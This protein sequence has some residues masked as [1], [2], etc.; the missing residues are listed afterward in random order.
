VSS[1]AKLFSSPIQW[2]RESSKSYR[3]AQR[4]GWLD[5]LSQHMSRPTVHNLL[6]HDDYVTW[7][8]ANRSEIQVLGRYTKAHTNI[9]HL[10]KVCNK[11]WDVAPT[12]IKSGSGCPNCAEYGFDLRKPAILY[13]VEHRLKYGRTRI[14]VGITNNDLRRRYVLSDLS[15]IQNAFIIEGDGKGIFALEKYLHGELRY[16]LD[17]KGL[18]LKNKIGAKECFKEDF[19][20]VLELALDAV[21]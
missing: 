1:K 18:R 10:C 19:D 3:A 21:T 2:Q 4:N 13:I 6:N 16:C 7:L 20:E 15:T 9:S 12:E 17:S 5:E 14:N 8:E 11:P